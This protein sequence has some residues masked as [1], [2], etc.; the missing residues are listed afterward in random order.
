M[1]HSALYSALVVTM[2]ASSCASMPKPDSDA[3]PASAYKALIERAEVWS[4]TRISE[5]NLRTGPSAKDGF[6]PLETVRCKY[7]EEKMGGK[8]PKFTCE[9]KDGDDLKVKYGRA[10]GEVFA[11]VAASRLLWA[12]GFGA[13][14]MY[15][16]KVEC[17]GCP[18]ELAKA[19]MGATALGNGV[20]RFDYAAVERKMDGVEVESEQGPGWSWQ[21]LD[22]IK[23][24][25]PHGRAHRDAL[26]L[27]AVMLQHTDSKREQQR[28][29][30]L[31]KGVDD[32][33]EEELA[34][35][36]KPFMM[37]SDLGKTFGKANAF[38]AD[39][40]GSA[41]LKA[42]RESPV[43]TGKT[44]CK[45][46]LFPSV[47]GTLD[48]P[49]ISEEGR[50]FLAELLTQLTTAQLR[51][52]FDVARFNERNAGT[53]AQADVQAWVNTFQDKVAEIGGRTCP[54]IVGSK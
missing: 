42:W 22:T 9:L 26:K 18:A 44:G 38:N 39:N 49:M 40:P 35:C 19:D 27:L 30:C 21:E 24:A 12:L 1:T 43:W 31:D 34:E 37:I 41:N 25:A 11:E 17:E 54:E 46:N 13:D 10:N 29:V 48:D 36:A 6:E 5:M 50:K 20:T 32:D 52:V 14:R 16:V 33:D 7:K 4:P 53:D 2:M 3:I 15:P 47:T 8:T 45:G 51:D 23:P 28:M